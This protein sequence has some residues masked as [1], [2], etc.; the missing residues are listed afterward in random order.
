ML[1][2]LKFASAY[3]DDIIVHSKSH[4]EHLSHLEFVFTRL[5][6]AKLKIKL[7]KCHFG[8]RETK[9]LGYVISAKGIRMNAA[10][11]EAIKDY[12]VQDQHGKPENGM[13]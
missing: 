4:E 12:P 9:F 8:C 10:K 7:R 11:I 6:Q 3:I 1:K 5:R 2:G 13:V